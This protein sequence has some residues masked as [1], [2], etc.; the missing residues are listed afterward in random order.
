MLLSTLTKDLVL[1]CR[2]V[3][4]TQ[5]G[6]HRERQSAQSLLQKQNSSCDEVTSNPGRYM[7]FF[8]GH[9]LN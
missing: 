5:W 9:W 3:L 7:T 4:E 1:S 8:G 6:H 2:H